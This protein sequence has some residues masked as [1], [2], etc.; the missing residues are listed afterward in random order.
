MLRASRELACLRLEEKR[1][2]ARERKGTGRVT[3]RP[4]GSASGRVK[5]VE[6]EMEE[7]GRG[8][9]RVYT[10]RGRS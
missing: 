7:G 5:G 1:A 2:R 8:G 6:E 4:R 3:R 10:W 9:D